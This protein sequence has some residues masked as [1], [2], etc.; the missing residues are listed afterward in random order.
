MGEWQPQP[1]RGDKALQKQTDPQNVPFSLLPHPT[2]QFHPMQLPQGRMC[3]WPQ[4]FCTMVL[5]LGWR[6]GDSHQ[7]AP[8]GAAS[9]SVGR[10]LGSHPACACPPCP[11]SLAIPAAS[12]G[13][14][15][16]WHCTNVTLS[17]AAVAESCRSTSPSSSTWGQRG[18]SELWGAWQ[19]QH[20]PSSSQ[21]GWSL[22]PW[23][24]L[25]GPGPLPQW[26]MDVS[27]GHAVVPLGVPG[28]VFGV[29]A[30]I[31]DADSKEACAGE[32]VRRLWGPAVPSHRLRA[33]WGP[34]THPTHSHRGQGWGQLWVQGH[35][36]SRMV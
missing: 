13:T 21:P 18:G 17:M 3:A 12:G 35:P 30:V 20:C 10:G 8:V 15:S 29:S 26:D 2:P 34:S 25:E 22:C 27:R 24:H 16:G 6:Q 33:P 7:A 1:G 11:H 14:T 31:H 5:S 36:S 28:Q 19:H 9:T 4:R 32:A 23:V